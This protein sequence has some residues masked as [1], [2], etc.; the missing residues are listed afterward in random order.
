MADDGNKLALVDAERNVLKNFRNN[1]AAHKG[2]G[3][4][5]DFKIIVHGVSSLPFR[6][7][8]IGQAQQPG[9]QAQSR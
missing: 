3:N 7:L 2:L 4:M 5:I 1:T 6:G 8:Q 9:G